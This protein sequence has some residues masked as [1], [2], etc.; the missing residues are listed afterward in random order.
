MCLTYDNTLVDFPSPDM[1]NRLHG[2]SP[3][4]F[5]SALRTLNRPNTST[6]LVRETEK[7]LNAVFPW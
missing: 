6:R 1:E 4:S 2:S 7:R 5:G 3:T